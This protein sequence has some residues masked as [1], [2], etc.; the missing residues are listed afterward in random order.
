MML[1]RNNGLFSLV[2]SVLGLVLALA[3]L[4]T[5]GTEAFSPTQAYR[6]FGFHQISGIARSAKDSGEDTDLDKPQQMIL[7]LGGS[8]YIGRRVCKELIESSSG[9]DENTTTKVVSISRSGMPPSWF[10]DDE[11]SS[12]SEKV[13]W[14]Q[15][16][17]GSDDAEE[18]SLATKITNICEA[19]TKDGN[20]VTPWETTIVGCI[21]NVNPAQ[22][23]EQL[24]GL[25]F[26][27]DRLLEENGSVYE[28]F[29][30]ETESLYTTTT[31]D[32]TQQQL[33]VIT[34]CVLLSLDY[35]C[36]KCLEG[37]I[38]GYIDGKRLAEARFLEAVSATNGGDTTDPS[39]LERVVVI[40]LPNFVYGGKRFPGFGATYRKL[41]ESPPA[42]AYVKGNDAL[43][44]LSV[45]EPED[46][47]EA[48][49][50][51]TIV[52]LLLPCV[53]F[54]AMIPPIFTVCGISR[55]N[56]CFVSCFVLARFD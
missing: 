7:V 38:E 16:E 52:V 53:V 14:I 20:V 43:R 27:D 24:W 6:D 23:W 29:F 34:R 49:V 22:S 50:R 41:V 47:V 4:S 46:W 28:S 17:I 3:L 12:W 21:G 26:D 31:K 51:I 56:V 44:S 39:N 48:V 9:D 8:G 35:T 5:T 13:E 11:S 18:D 10:L 37:P 33:L 40:G 45:A 2:G 25:S 1:S 15:H 55:S 54:G 19:G 36:Q 42:K 30:N 32:A